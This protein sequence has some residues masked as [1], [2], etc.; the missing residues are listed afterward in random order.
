MNRRST[1]LL[2]TFWTIISFSVQAQDKI[3]IRAGYQGSAFYKNGSQLPGTDPYGSFY[4]GIFKDNKVI[5]A[6]H[7]G[8]GLEYMQTGMK[9][10]DKNKQVLGYLSIPVYAKAKIGPFFGLGG[11][12]ANIKVSEKVFVNGT[13]AKPTDEQKSETMDFPVF[14]GAGA[15]LSIFTLEARYHWGISDINSGYSS[16]YFQ[17]G[18]GV[19][20]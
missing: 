1:L 8:I 5:P 7:L 10:D 12:G 19:S 11:I 20:F 18:A 4:V 16:Q 2:I 3:G 13:S 6:V 17:L 14:L 15:M 9:V